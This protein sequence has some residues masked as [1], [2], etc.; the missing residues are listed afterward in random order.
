MKNFAILTLLMPVF[1]LS[2][3]N[4]EWTANL[5]HPGSFVSGIVIHNELVFITHT[6]NNE[7][8]SF[9][10]FSNT[11]NLV[12]SST[13]AVRIRRL[14]FNGGEVYSI[15]DSYV[16]RRN[17]A[18]N[19]LSEVSL[20]W[21]DG[22]NISTLNGAIRNNYIYTYAANDFLKHRLNGEQILRIEVAKSGNSQNLTAGSDFIY[23]YGRITDPVSG[24]TLFQLD[25]LG[26]QKWSVHTGDVRAM[27]ADES[28][29]C[30]TAEAQGESIL[31]KRDSEGKL[32]W[33]IPVKEQFTQGMFRL[34]DSLF[35]CGASS[36]GS[37]TY[38]KQVCA[39]SIVSASTG[40]I[41]HQQTIR[42]KEDPNE[43]ELFSQIA[44]DGRNVYIGGS[45][46]TQGKNCFLLKL[47][48]NGPTGLKDEKGRG[49]SFNVFPNPGGSK[50]TITC[51]NNQASTAN[52]TVRNISGQVVYKKE[53]SCNADKSFTL[54]LGKQ[55]AGNYTVEIVSGQ[56][57]AVKKIVVE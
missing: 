2:Q 57:K 19:I 33:S 16:T 50:F 7:G 42:M 37:G 40:K 30:Y 13:T 15:G 34:G 8:S 32:V 1:A 6:D 5:S 56:E 38:G 41:V 48:E 12:H 28:G 53:I 51:K 47:S 24:P 17:L 39:F 44:S 11:G 3:L 9:S 27:L 26:N 52:I 10:I 25:T 14:V 55:A 29:N 46:G 35:L 43:L 4:I 45:T 54:D 21:K 31:N 23:I 49:S 20:P 18:G 22:D 36:L